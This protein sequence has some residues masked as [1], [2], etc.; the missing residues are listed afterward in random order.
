M[1]LIG[2]RRAWAVLGA[3]ALVAVIPACGDE[4][5]DTACCQLL[6]VCDDCGCRDNVWTI[7]S[8]GEGKACKTALGEV[9]CNSS[10]VAK[11]SAE[12]ACK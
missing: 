12:T 3:L 9:I 8:S 1:K 6:L 7:A 4:D 11:S 10:T 5:V 2:I